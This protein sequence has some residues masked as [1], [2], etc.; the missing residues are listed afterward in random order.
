MSKPLPMDLRERL[1]SAVEGGEL[2]DLFGPSLMRELGLVG[3][4]S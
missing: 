1:V 4:S 3:S 2:P